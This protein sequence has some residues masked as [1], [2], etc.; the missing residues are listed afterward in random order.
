MIINGK[1][2]LKALFLIGILIKGSCVF[3]ESVTWPPVM[4]FPMITLSDLNYAGSGCPFGSLTSQLSSGRDKV[5]LIFKDYKIIRAISGNQ[6]GS[7][8]CN[9]VVSINVPTG[10][11]ISIQKIELRGK[12]KLPR[13]AESIFSNEY[14]FAGHLGPILSNKFNGPYDDSF[15]VEKN[16]A[17]QEQIFSPCGETALL[18]VNSSFV[19][20]NPSFDTASVSIDGSSPR[21]RAGIIYSLRWKKCHS[22][23][24][25]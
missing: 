6:G 24:R 5:Q 1:I 23:S 18:R 22:I 14:A 2:F 16:I 7:K 17:L 19:V 3:A 20:K 21:D 10:Y 15:K 9:F 13:G 12:M 25:H 8:N 4:T 11:A